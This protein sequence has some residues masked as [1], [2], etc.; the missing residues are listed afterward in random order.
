MI[1]AEER[2]SFTRVVGANW[3]PHARVVF[4]RCLRCG[5][6]TCPG[7]VDLLDCT[8]LINGLTARD[9][10]VERDA[11]LN[12]VRQMLWLALGQA[13]YRERLVLDA[14]L[15]GVDALAHQ[16]RKDGRVNRR[17]G[18]RGLGQWLATLAKELDTWAERL[19][20]AR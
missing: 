10:K 11:H 17:R 7:R 3:N 9:E 12:A 2:D 20:A 13:A 6:D 14:A 18:N 15:E 19:R 4:V 8:L 16:L 1:S 5:S